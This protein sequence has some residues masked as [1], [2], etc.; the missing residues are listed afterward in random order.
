MNIY[1]GTDHAGYEMKEKLLLFLKQFGHNIFDKGAFSND[2]TDDYPDFVQPVARAVQEDNGSVGIVLGKSGQGE[3]MCAN[4]FKDVR[5]VVYYGGN[6]DLV[7]LGREHNDA[8]ILSLGADFVNQ[9]EA[10]E[11]IKIFLQTDFSKVERHI[12]RI[13]KIDN[14]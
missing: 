14:I 7:R 4:R 3:A 1:I 9:F 11:A 8:N 6:L 2:S 12:R 10:E 13:N 5:A